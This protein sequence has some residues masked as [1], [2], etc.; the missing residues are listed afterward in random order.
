MCLI[1]FWKVVLGATGW[2]LTISVENRKRPIS[3]FDCGVADPLNIAWMAVGTEGG[4]VKMEVEVLAGDGVTT[5]KVGEA[6]RVAA[7]AVAGPG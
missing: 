6:S 7:T 2:P 5:K 3:L 4:G 1:G